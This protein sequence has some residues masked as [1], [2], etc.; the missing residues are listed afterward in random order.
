MLAILPIDAVQ[1]GDSQIGLV[2]QRRCVEGVARG[3][4]GQLALGDGVELFVDHGHEL[5]QGLRVPA[6]QLLE[7]YRDLSLVS[8]VVQPAGSSSE[9]S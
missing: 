7:Q 8:L 6:G 2:H 4:T 9:S 5:A 1:P 3:L